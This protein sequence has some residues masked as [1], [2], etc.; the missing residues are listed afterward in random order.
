MCTGYTTRKHPGG[1]GGGHGLREGD[2]E[3]DDDAE[4]HCL[5]SPLSPPHPQLRVDE[6]EVEEEERNKKNRDGDRVS[7][8][9]SPRR[10]RKDDAGV[11]TLE[12]DYCCDS[13]LI[14]SRCRID[15]APTSSSSSSRIFP[16]GVP[17][18]PSRGGGIGKPSHGG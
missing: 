7:P 5:S 3:D 11:V 6:K 14:H 2:D 9:L 8:L 12:I 17:G 15:I 18:T 4:H 13:P 16:R 10:G 1:G